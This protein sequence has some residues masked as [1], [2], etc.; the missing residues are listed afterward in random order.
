MKD[1]DV[2][3]VKTDYDDIVLAVC[4]AYEADAGDR[5]E[6]VG[7]GMGVVL[8]RHWDANSEF[9]SMACFFTAVR[10]VKSV[11]KKHWELAEED[12]DD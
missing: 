3:V 10:I 1:R 7:G 9:Q 5:V 4:P 6:L 2:L 8:K 11:W 12:D